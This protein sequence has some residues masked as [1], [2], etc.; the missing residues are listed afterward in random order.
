ME[1]GAAIPVGGN[2]A[3]GCCAARVAG[4]NPSVLG[5]VGPIDMGG[6]NPMEAPT[7]GTGGKPGARA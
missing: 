1:G 2:G 4:V 6:A 3:E 7:G 5:A